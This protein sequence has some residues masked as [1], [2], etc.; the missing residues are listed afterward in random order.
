MA[1]HSGVLAWRIPGM[2][3]PGGLPSLG[4]HRVGHDWSDLAAAAVVISGGFPVSS[5]K[6]FIFQC[7]RQKKL[8]FDPS[9]G[10]IPWRR[11]WPP[12]P[13]FLLRKSHGQRSLRG[14]SLQCHKESGMTKYA[15]TQAQAIFIQ[16]LLSHLE[17]SP[18]SLKF[19]QS[20]VQSWTFPPCR[21]LLQLSLFFSMHHLHWHCL[22]SW[23]QKK[24]F[25]FILFV[26]TRKHQSSNI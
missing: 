13:I 3:E 20:H 12:T 23:P 25:F 19:L 4:S 9:M 14:Y 10:K 7:R 22:Y 18:K 5:G 6:E 26:V 1:T 11:K 8:G 24:I 2:G 16:R 21:Q 15:G 17:H